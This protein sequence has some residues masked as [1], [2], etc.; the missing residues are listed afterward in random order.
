MCTHTHTRTHSPKTDTCKTCDAYKVKVDAERDEATL[1]QLHGEWELHHCKAE[2]AYQQLKEDSA[3]A[4]S[5]PNMLEITFDLQQ[6]LPTPVLTTNVV[7]Y[8][9]PLWT[10]N[11]GIHNCAA[12]SGHMHLWH[13]G[14]ASRGSHE[15]ASCVLKYL[16]YTKPTATHLVTYSDLCGGQNRNVYFLSLWLYIVASDEFPITVV[17]QKFMTVGHSYLPNDRDFG[18]IEAER[19]K[20]DTLYIPKEWAQ[21]IRDSRKKKHFLSLK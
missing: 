20:R 10:Y 3:H 14:M 15:I 21:L 17:D 13:E 5:N 11:L 19:R 16:K 1:R 7:F 12:E 6:S 8:K 4:K 9:H 2:R 18:S